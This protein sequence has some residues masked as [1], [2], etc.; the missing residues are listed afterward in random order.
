VQKVTAGESDAYYATRPLGAR[1]SAWASAQSETVGKREVLERA[2]EEARR[3][4]GENPARPP[5]WGGYRVE[6]QEL[7]F[8]QGRSDRL[9]DRLL[10][11]RAAGSWT[12]ERLSP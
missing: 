10:Y 2:M 7:E 9:H 8:W 11:K 6:P 1:L 5:H 3:R 4:H 12:I